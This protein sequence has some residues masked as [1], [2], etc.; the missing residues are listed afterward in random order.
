MQTSKYDHALSTGIL[1]LEIEDD[2]SLFPDELFQIA[3]RENP[4]RAFLFVS[5]LLGRHIPASPSLHRTALNALA[6]RAIPH[7]GSGSVLVMS[8]AETAV[9]LGLGV[10][11]ALC[12][13]CPELSIGFLP[14]T[15][16]SPDGVVPWINA[17]EDHSHAVEHMI[18][19][20]RKGVLPETDEATLVLVDD[21]TTTGNTFKGLAQE[22]YLSGVAFNRVVLVTLTDWSDNQS[23]AAVGAA[24]PNASV[25]AVS[26]L[27]GRYT[28]TPSSGTTPHPLPP[29]CPPVCPFWS[30]NLDVP[31]GVP[32]SGLNSE[33]FAR[34][35]QAWS[36]YVDVE[37]L[38]LLAPAARVLVIGTG[39]HV[40]YPFLAAE[41]ISEQGH[42][43]RFISTTRSPV[44]P[45]T[46]IQKQI[47]FPDHY[48]L[49]IT[50][51]LN[52]VDPD[53]WDE[54]ILFTETDLGGIPEALRSALG[55]CWIVDG[56]LKVTSLNKETLI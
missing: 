12:R 42:E 43:T 25:S 56:S 36:E 39:E 38:P 52:N 29:G 6:D 49:G 13:N 23:I 2:D 7:L 19:P 11:D 4:K 28:W 3:E 21:E 15:R 18:L 1:T 55:R 26:L 30:P 45:G 48:G 35:I 10:F 33:D 27:S 20:P 54:I 8:Y 51:Y 47:S 40:W 22:L 24:L 31:F 14:T 41:I 46:V 37:I 16:F 34:D 5:T 50:M 53:R 9:G 17:R 32:R 44:L